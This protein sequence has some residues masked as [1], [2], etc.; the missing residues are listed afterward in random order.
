MW[1]VTV[2]N[3]QMCDK[4]HNYAL[5]VQSVDPLPVVGEYIYIST[6]GPTAFPS[7]CQQNAAASAFVARLHALCRIVVFLLIKVLCLPRLGISMFR[8]GLSGLA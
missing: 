6:T 5:A 1:L 2:E 8:F 7:C 4:G 3:D